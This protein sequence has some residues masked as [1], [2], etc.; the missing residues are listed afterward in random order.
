MKVRI[1]TLAALAAFAALLADEQ[2]KVDSRLRSSEETLARAGRELAEVREAGAR[3]RLRAGRNSGAAAVVEERLA[4][5]ERDAARGERLHRITADE[6]ERVRRALS[7][8]TDRLSRDVL[9]P[10]IQVNGK[11]SV[12]GGT[13]IQSRPDGKGGFATYAV[14]AFHVLQKAVARKDGSETRDPVEVRVYA[15]SGEVQESLDAELVAYD[16]RKDLALLRFRSSR[17]FEHVARLAPRETLRSVTVF[18]PVYAVGCPLGHDP[19]PSPG[20]ISTL[21]KEVGGERFWMMNAPTI[22]GNSGGGIFHRDTRELL[23]IAAMICTYDGFVSTPVPHLGIMVS[24]LTV[25]DWLD[26]QYL[27]FAYDPGVT[28]E[29]C[30]RMRLD[31]SRPHPP[32]T[33]ARFEY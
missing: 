10:S 25:Y 16:E 28:P 2:R 11:G 23:G 29:M 15:A 21:H 19:L 33:R 30:E 5:L 1:A 31:A 17:K 24:L 7:R 6:I 27:R 3:E 9:L 22:F 14:T 12:G 32:T 20:E 8:D 26:A 18:T 4:A 13:V